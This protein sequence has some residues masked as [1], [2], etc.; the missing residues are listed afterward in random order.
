MLSESM[1]AAPTS[2]ATS[3]TKM[4]STQS[5]N[6]LL[7]FTLPPRQSRP[8]PSLPRRSRKTN[9]QYGVWNKERF[10]NAQYRFVMNPMGDYTVHFAD[11]DIF[12]Q[13]NDILQVIIPRSSAL[14]SAA[15]NEEYEGHTSCPI[16]LSAP[17]APRMTKCG[18]IFCFPCILHYL[19]TSENKWAR[20]PICF[21]SVTSAQ[22]KSVKWFDGPV[23]SNLNDTPPGTSTSS[24][25]ASSG[26]RD[27]S[28]RVGAT[29]SMR[30]IQRPQITTLALP[31]SHTWPSDLLHPHQA[32]F[33]FLPDIYIYA[34]FMLATPDMLVSDLTKDLDDLTVE[35]RILAGMNDDLGVLFIDAAEVKVRNQIAKATA[36]HTP[37]LR[38]RIEKA[39]RDL[40]EIEGRFTYRERRRI[41][42]ASKAERNDSV[43]YDEGIPQELLSLKFGS[44][45]PT[46]P[47]TPNNPATPPTNS[48]RNNLNNS[49]L[50]PKQRRNV[51]P[52]P[53]S[54]STYY[55][56]QAASGLP[57]YLHPLDIRI[58]LSHFSSYASFPDNITIRVEALSEG[59]VNDDL[60]KRCKYLA[61]IPEGADVV[62]VE[63]NL[64]DVVGKE[65]LKNFEGAL[66][67][68]KLRRRD[69]GRKDERARAR[70]EEREKEKRESEAAIEWR[71]TPSAMSTEFVSRATDEDVVVAD[72]SFPGF[73]ESLTRASTTMPSSR[74]QQQEQQ[75]AS[76]VWGSRSFASALHSN[77]PPLPPRN[78]GSA[79]RPRQIEEDEWE[80][81]IAWHELEQRS[82]GDNGG[83][84]KRSNKLVVLGGGG[85]RRR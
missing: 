17:N 8:P 3:P 56:Y 60:R 26:P 61:H 21:D 50:I 16:C 73:E 41:E 84:R 64:D 14:A 69:K 43:P 22:L 58:L 10:V 37:A 67:M 66:K 47:A 45:T 80:M 38:E 35:K 13:W 57:L 78:G 27:S 75:R 4:G 85:G 25:S 53:P 52:P 77:T 74:P 44:I 63:A 65:G 1:A 54:T 29:L 49:R 28:P 55:Y 81:D 2:Q 39:T 15:A 23:S 11:P 46:L 9:N 20:C 82:N 5:L 79:S 30:L 19:N 68:R 72:G 24:S 83:R 12:F 36:L 33:H 59:T 32:P 51:N 76:G 6:H 48:K 34:K 70:A 62:F 71:F 42:E 40:R 18:H 31:R 7:N